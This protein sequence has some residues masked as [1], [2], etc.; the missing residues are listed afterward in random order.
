MRAF[1]V[2]AKSLESAQILFNALRRF[3]P[4]LDGSSSEGY[5]VSVDVGAD[6][7]RIL[8]VLDAIQQYVHEGNDMARVELDGRKYTVFPGQ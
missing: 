6:S 4:A 3:D 5:S 2:K 8:E 1:T 7:R